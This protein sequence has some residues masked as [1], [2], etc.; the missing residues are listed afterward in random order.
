MKKIETIKDIK[1]DTQN[2]NK[3][4]LDGHKYL[5]KSLK[6]Y[7]ALRSIVTDKDGNVIA[8]N[9]TLENY[10]QLG[11][12]AI[13][14]VETNG[15]K[16]V[17][18]KRNDLALNSNKGRQAAFADNYTSQIGLEWDYQHITQNLDENHLENWEFN[19]PQFEAELIDDGLTIPDVEVID[20][21]SQIETQ[22]IDELGD[23]TDKPKPDKVA[24]AT[25]FKTSIYDKL[26]D[27]LTNID[28]DCAKALL[29]VANYF[30]SNY[31]LENN[32]ELEARLH[33]VKKF[34]AFMGSDDERDRVYKIVGKLSK[35]STK[36]ER[37]VAV[38]YVGAGILAALRLFKQS[39]KNK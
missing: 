33:G 4:T 10:Q 9:K 38:S 19:M 32:D 11:N 8:G 25:P 22:D 30:E 16:L 23:I 7:G 1:K 18:V 39:D 3:G 6:N 15:D 26:I 21:E 27:D 17:V 37:D 5:K 29:L 13:E 20:D 36:E 12:E 24:L 35:L 28:E 31:D 14:V 2:F 34:T